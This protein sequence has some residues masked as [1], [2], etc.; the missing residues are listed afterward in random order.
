[1]HLAC[2]TQHRPVCAILQRVPV[3]RIKLW[4][5]KELRREY[6]AKLQEK[7]TQ[8]V[9]QVD[10]LERNSREAAEEVC[11]LTTGRRCRELGTRWWCDEVQQKIKE[12]K[13]AYKA[14]KRSRAEADKKH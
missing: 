7:V 14:W 5:L 3:N 6:E 2:L 1:M 8:R 4:K 12:K 11:G 13:A 10:Q 9:E